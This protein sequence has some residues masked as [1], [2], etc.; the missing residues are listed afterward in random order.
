MTDLFRYHFRPDRGDRWRRSSTGPINRLWAAPAVLAVLT[1]RNAGVSCRRSYRR[2]DD[3][4][5]R[6][7][8]RGEGTGPLFKVLISYRLYPGASLQPRGEPEG[9]PRQSHGACVLSCGEEARS[10]GGRSQMRQRDMSAAW[11]AP[12]GCLEAAGSTGLLDIALRLPGP[13]QRPMGSGPASSTIPF[14]RERPSRSKSEMPQGPLNSTRSRLLR[15]R[16]PP[17][18]RQRPSSR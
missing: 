18:T 15:Q 8:V 9:A 12:S 2:Y 1:I 11:D 5:R 4:G 16:Q 17:G 13:P 14:L 7:L 10:C 6:P 3:L